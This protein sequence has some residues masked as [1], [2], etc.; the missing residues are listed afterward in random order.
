[1]I[2]TKEWLAEQNACGDGI[3]LFEKHNIPDSGKWLDLL[4]HGGDEVR[5]LENNTRLI[6]ANWLTIRLLSRT[7]AIRYAVF[8][9]RQVLGIYE[10]EYPGDARVRD[11]INAAEALIEDP[12]NDDLK[13]AAWSA[14]WAAAR[15]V[16]WAVGWAAGWSAGWSVEWAAEWSVGWAVAW[17]VERSVGWSAARCAAWA[18]AWSVE[19]SAERP[20]A[21][22]AARSVG[23]SAAWAAAMVKI[24]EYGD[25]IITERE[26]QSEIE[27]KDCAAGDRL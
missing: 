3:A 5:E 20:A 9:V 10:K 14:A 18:V 2:I 15:S 1:M 13:S 24:L 21:R 27:S 25:G 26:A 11:A 16:E 6:W 8:A 19:R 4:I 23:W 12:N 22:S 17:S 7:D